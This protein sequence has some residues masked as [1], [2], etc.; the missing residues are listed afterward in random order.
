M[1][2]YFN[3]HDREHH[4]IMMVFGVVTQEWLDRCKSITPDERKWIK[5]SL[6]WLRKAYESMIARSS[7]EYAKALKN[8]IK[9]SDLF[10]EDTT[11][12]CIPKEIPT[13]TVARE[14]YYDLAQYA[15][16]DC[17]GCQVKDFNECHKYHLF[18]RLEVPT[19]DETTAECP[20]LQPEF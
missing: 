18:M 15:L 20:Y 5:T 4:V 1:K 6:T 19:C 16:C 12:K 13:K 11:G 9:H 3:R 8:T 2:Q 14:D 7:Y 17:R 10:L